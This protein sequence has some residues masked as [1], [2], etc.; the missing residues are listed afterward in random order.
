MYLKAEVSIKNSAGKCAFVRNLGH[1]MLNEYEVQIGGSRIDRQTGDF[2][3][4]QQSLGLDSNKKAAYDKMIGNVPELTEMKNRSTETKYI[5]YIPLN[6]WFCRNVGLSLPMIALQY[7]DVRVQFNFREWEKLVVKDAACTDLEVKI[8]NANLL[9][10]YVFL[11]ADERKAFATTTHEFL[12]EQLQSPDEDPISEKSK[13]LRLVFNHPCKYLTWG[14]KLGRYTSNQQFFA[15]HPS[16]ID[17]VKRRTAELIYLLGLDIEKGEDGQYKI[18]QNDE[19]DGYKKHDFEDVTIRKFLDEISNSAMIVAKPD[20]LNGNCYL[21][22]PN[23]ESDPF[24]TVEFVDDSFLT[25]DTLTKIVNSPISSRFRSDLGKLQ[26]PA[27]EGLMRHFVNVNMWDNYGVTFDGKHNP[28][29]AAN[30]QINGQ[31]RFSKRDGNYFNYVQPYQHFYSTPADGVNVYSF[32]LKPLDHQPSGTCNFS[33][34]DFAQLSVDLT[35]EGK[36]AVEDGADSTIVVYT[37]NYN[38]LRVMGGMGGVAYA[39]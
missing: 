6:F 18:N 7:H 1:A 38:V 28:I 29:A 33:R 35:D 21:L 17:F 14:C 31:D 23:F 16:D 13:K 22:P 2:M 5:M 11:D 3:N 12:I 26:G 4:I 36:T 34:I 39:N 37:V 9:T 19:G 8:T 10:D 15:Y 25:S 24:A 20:E 32:A 27:S 30:V